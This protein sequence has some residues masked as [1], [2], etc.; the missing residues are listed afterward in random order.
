[1]KHDPLEFSALKEC[2][3]PYIASDI[4]LDA[5]SSLVPHD[6]WDTAR[7]HLNMLA[8]MMRLVASG[9]EPPF[10][11]IPD[12][13]PLLKVHE[14]ALLEGQDI[15]KMAGCIQ[16]I[17]R[18]RYELETAGGL[19]GQAAEE[20]APLE[21][22]TSRIGY[23]LLP[24]GEV[25]ERANP[26]LKDLRSRYRAV[27]SSI[28]EKLEGIVET[29]K[30]KAVLMEDIITKRNDRFVIPLRHDYG[31]HLK[32]IT[33]DYSRTNRTVYVEPLT[34]VNENNTLNQLKSYMIEE[35][36]KVLRSLTSLVHDH[37]HEIRKNLGIY[38]EFDLLHACARWALKNDAIIPDIGG[39][40]ISLTAARH[41][42]LFK[43]LGKDTVPLDIRIPNDKD[44]L[45]ISGP[46][47][48]GKT[49]ALKTLGLLILMAKCGLAIPAREGSSICEVGQV[50]VEMDT[51]Q[52][53]THDLSSF[54]AHA[55]SLKEIYEHVQPGD[56]V[57]LDE[58][59]TGT[60][61]EHGGALAVSCIHALRG[62]G[63]RVVATSHSDLIKLYG[64]S[65]ENVEIAATAFDDTGMKPLFNLVYGVIG[66]SRAFEI[67]EAISFPRSLIEEARGIVGRQGNTALAQAI[68][69]ISQATLMRDEAARELKE[70]AELRERMNTSI[71]EMERDRVSTA[72]RYKRLM[73]QVELMT[74]KP[75][76][77]EA[78]REIEETQE[79]SDL[80]GILETVQPAQSLKVDIGAHVRIKG[81][82][83]IGEVVDLAY[84]SAEVLFGT[85]RL[86]ISLDQLEVVREKT[87][88][89]G[90]KKT[91]K[92]MSTPSP[93]MP[94][95]VVGMRV[96]EAIPVVEQALDRAV[97]SGQ[98]TLEIIHGAGTGRLKK[99]IRNYLK[100]LPVVKAYQD[101]SADSGGG[102]KT[103]VVLSTR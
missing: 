95:V 34:V 70:A 36:H 35:E 56:L 2:I 63:A 47:A 61:P 26:V 11:S 102:N 69:D 76:A 48:G 78:I 21:M 98:E 74:R 97:L 14:G 6:S 85:K 16:D 19:L 22:V 71:Q 65:T 80:R 60:D 38:G 40:G 81:G 87:L 49:V 7:M 66:T 55:L 42:L 84:D 59:G 92:I 27:R 100:D 54:T 20:I 8:E 24:T 64:I 88:R 9:K 103:V 18:L 15:V 82:D 77:P 51:S 39:D 93:V 32:G 33:H 83:L 29:L 52:D 58:P 44:C 67:L 79:A 30:T 91:R 28:L 72:L 41:P 101:G 89:D 86:R 12:I 94:I 68:Q 53:I 45:I 62:K 50:F 5:L 99:A 57:L 3:Q 13:T 73:D 4:G 96:D 90:K 37:A 43:R 17:A 46:N 75:Q 31:V 10:P 25:S 1:M 23:V